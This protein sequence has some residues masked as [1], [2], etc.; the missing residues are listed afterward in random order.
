MRT[1]FMGILLFFSAIISSAQIFNP[2]GWKTEVK[3]LENGTFELQMTASIEEGWHLYSQSL[4]SD[5]GPIATE[6]TFK[7]SSDFEK[8]GKVKE[9]KAKTEFDLNFDMDLN[10]FEKKVTFTQKIKSLNARGFSATA[11][12]YFM[13]CDAEK[14]LP[15]EYV[16]FEFSIPANTASEASSEEEETTGE[17]IEN[18]NPAQI[19]EGS[20]DLSNDYLNAT[21]WEYISTKNAEGS[22]DFH[23]KGTIGEG[24]HLYS[25]KQ[26][27]D[28]E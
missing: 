2:V 21:K 22:Y 9:P 26:K 20:D 25:Q 14:C 11:E 15:P 24:W 8:I 18:D 5:D 28:E 17:V 1:L 23:F 16:D 27:S 6:F 19:I 13:V 12:V 4:P 3:Q 7:E 10:Y